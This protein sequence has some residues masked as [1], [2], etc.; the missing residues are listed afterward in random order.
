MET[1]RNGG[2]LGEDEVGGAVEKCGDRVEMRRD[3]WRW[4]ETWKWGGNVE[5]DENVWR[6]METSGDVWRY[7][8]TIGDVQMCV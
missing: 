4:V 6:S 1:C 3:I 8:E 2:R 7:V 5:M